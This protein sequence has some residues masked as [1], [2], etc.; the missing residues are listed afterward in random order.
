MPKREGIEMKYYTPLR[1]GHNWE[2]AIKVIEAGM[3]GFQISNCR[4]Y[5][6]EAEFASYLELVR[7]LQEEAD[8]GFTVHAPRMD[9]HL[10]SLNS[11][12][13]SA[14]QKELKA[15]LDLARELEASVVVIH[16]APAILNMPG[17]EWSKQV[18]KPSGRAG[19]L[20]KKQESHLI[21]SLKDLADYAPDIILAVKNLVFPHEL[22]RSPEDMQRLIDVVNRPN[23][24]V[25]FDAGHALV[26]GY[27]T[28]VFLNILAKHV[29][30]VHLHDNHGIVDEH[31][32]LGRGTVDYV[33]IIQTLK[34]IEYLGVV[35][36]EFALEDAGEF[37]R[38]LLQ[39][40]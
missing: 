6:A 28:A 31:L 2:Y 5:L 21:R 40:K 20:A 24:G 34:E 11:N 14:A 36:L 23:V 30:H 25:T 19:Q 18:Y 26:A 4:S 3:Q 17:G 12:I 33:G 1:P 7:R 29:H 16:G 37:A 39:L 10:G 27:E 32:P 22:Y 9:V 38:Y 13:R 15:S 35:N 8:V